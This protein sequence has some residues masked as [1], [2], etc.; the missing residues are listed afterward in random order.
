MPVIISLLPRNGDLGWFY[1]PTKVRIHNYA[2]QGHGQN[3]IRKILRENYRINVSQSIISRTLNKKHVYKYRR[4]RPT[5]RP[6]KLTDREVRY[7]AYIVRKGWRTRRLLYK[8]LIKEYV[9]NDIGRDTLRRALYRLGYRR[10]IACKRAFISEKQ[11]IARLNWAY[12][13]R[14]CIIDGMWAKV[15]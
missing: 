15:I 10:C 7:V 9:G 6:Y 3:E 4:G 14:N 12:I 13:F 5:G 11:A 2:Q 8:Q 1:T